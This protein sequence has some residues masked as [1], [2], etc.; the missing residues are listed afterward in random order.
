VADFYAMYGQWLASRGGAPGPP[1]TNAEAVEWQEAD[2]ELAAA[3]WAKFSVRAKDLFSTLI[4][5]PGQTFSGEELAEM[6]QIPNG[7][8][9]VAGVLA[10]P[11]RHCFGSGRRYYWRWAYPDGEG[12]VYWM[13]TRLANLLSRCGR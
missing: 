5:S 10:W 4:D 12:A 9:G 1:G 13:D 7:R 6:H 8:H 3:V 2:V 11:S